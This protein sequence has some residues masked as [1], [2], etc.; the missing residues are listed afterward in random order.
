MK[1]SDIHLNKKEKKDVLTIRSK[2][3]KTNN[4]FV[5]LMKKPPIDKINKLIKLE[6]QLKENKKKSKK[7]EK[8]KK[9]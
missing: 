8:A 9:K 1:E 3:K 2:I 4:K 7:K 6:N 5:K